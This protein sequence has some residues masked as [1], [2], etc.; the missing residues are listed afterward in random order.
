MRLP[1]RDIPFSRGQRF[2]GEIIYRRRRQPRRRVRH[3]ITLVLKPGQNIIGGLNGTRPLSIDKSSANN[4][5][6]DD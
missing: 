4:E 3:C 1:R 5:A 2:Y 6:L